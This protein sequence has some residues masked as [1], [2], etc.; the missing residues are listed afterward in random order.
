M[1]DIENEAIA[2][3]GGGITGLFCAYVLAGKAKIVH[4]FEASNRFGG[5]IRTIRLD[6]GNKELKGDCR[7][8]DLEF[9]VEFGPMRIELEIQ[10]LLEALLN[11]LKIK[12]ARTDKEYPGCEKLVP[13]RIGFPSFVSPTS[14]SD[15]KYNLLPEEIDKTPLELLQLA[16]LRVTMHLKVGEGANVERKLDGLVREIGRRGATLEPTL[17]YF[18]GWMKTLDQQD[19]WEIET[20]G[21]I[22]E[23]PLHAVGF[24]NLL[25]DY[26]SHDAITKLRDL[27][28]FYHLLAENPNAAEWYVW[29]LRGFAISDELQGIHGG[30]EYI[31]VRLRRELNKL[32]RKLEKP[33]ELEMHKMCAVKMIEKV[34]GRFFLNFRDGNARRDIQGAGYDRVMLALPRLGIERIVRDSDT[35]IMEGLDS[36]LNSLLDSAF[37][38]PMVKMFLVVRNRWWEEENRAN[39]YATRIPTRE[40]HYWKGKSAKSKQGLIMVYTD[41][42]AS[43]FW[44]NYTRPGEQ[45]DAARSRTH[46]RTKPATAPPTNSS[47]TQKEVPKGRRLPR[48]LEERLVRKMVQYINDND[49]PDI[50]QKDIAWYGI[51]DWGRAPYGAGNHAWRPE[52]KSWNVMRRLADL[53]QKKEGRAT[54]PS[55]HIC[56][57]AYSDYHGFME[58]SLRSAVYALHRILDRESEYDSEL[59]WLKEALGDINGDYLNG[60]QHW[61]EAL[62]NLKPEPG[63]H[64]YRWEDKDRD[65][66]PPNE[67]TGTW[68]LPETPTPRCN[69]SAGTAEKKAEEA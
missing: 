23:V 13:R 3:V 7:E 12:R 63:D 6:R 34:D 14:A 27:G 44:A 39:R 35:K 4:L 32:R 53:A 24:W 33:R 46:P 22:D 36:E 18:A 15:P 62:D 5:R 28:T 29:W 17:K 54:A 45:P 1:S 56:G 69:P 65:T 43:S 21:K 25:S 2:I 52:R 42:P 64:L 55:L 50:S 9:I 60:L 40:L 61:V 26:L 57:E 68:K 11:K 20:Q 47:S 51:W 66:E 67:D 41:R 58:G 48:R 38:F 59:R 37:G 49:V 30:M 16:M 8:Q 10:R 31:V 19:Y